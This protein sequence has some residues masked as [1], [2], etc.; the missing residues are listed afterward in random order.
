M[1]M[2]F[3][4]EPLPRTGIKLETQREVNKNM[5]TMNDAGLVCLEPSGGQVD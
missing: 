3:S 2:K 1:E 5:T 4:A